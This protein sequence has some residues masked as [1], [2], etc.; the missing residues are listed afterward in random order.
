MSQDDSKVR[1][2]DDEVFSEFP[3]MSNS[4]E[5]VHSKG[6]QSLDSKTAQ[7]NSKDGQ[8]N[9]TKGQ[10]SSKDDGIN[11]KDDTIKSMKNNFCSMN[12]QN[13]MNSNGFKPPSS[14]PEG[15]SSASS[16]DGGALTSAINYDEARKLSHQGIIY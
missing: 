7:I 2:S 4:P 10:L 9:L 16:T 13:L 14:P 1:D 5:Q 6:G 11:S 15:P 12:D 8:I 3:S